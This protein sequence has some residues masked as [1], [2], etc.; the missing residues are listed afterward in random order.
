VKAIILGI[1]LTLVLSTQAQSWA[2]WTVHYPT[3][4][5]PQVPKGDLLGGYST[6]KSCMCAGHEGLGPPGLTRDKDGHVVL[7]AVAEQEVLT[8]TFPDIEQGKYQIKVG[9]KCL[10][11][12]ID[13][14][15]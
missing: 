14:R 9:Y 7:V 6:L 4:S 12:N 11:D 1:I 15:K 5:V 8:M 2:L 13:P 3:E 10:P